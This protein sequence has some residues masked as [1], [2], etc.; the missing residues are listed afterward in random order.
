MQLLPLVFPTVEPAEEDPVR[1]LD[2][3][4]AVVRAGY[5]PSFFVGSALFR[6][7]LPDCEELLPAD[8]VASSV[9]V[10]ACSASTSGSTGFRRSV[11]PSLRVM[12][13]MRGP[14]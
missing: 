13:G 1:T 10:S 3:R 8:G 12:R 7:D 2:Q 14:L 5:R 9:W 4:L 11:M 6:R